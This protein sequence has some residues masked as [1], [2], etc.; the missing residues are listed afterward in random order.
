MNNINCAKD[1][2]RIA[3]KVAGRELIQ[4]AVDL[5]SLAFKVKLGTQ[6]AESLFKLQVLEVKV[7]HV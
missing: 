2:F 5:L 3:F 4:D 6:V 7:F 1:A